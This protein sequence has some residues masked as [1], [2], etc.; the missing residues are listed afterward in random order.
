ME[1]GVDFAKYTL[2]D[3]DVTRLEFY[4]C[5]HPFYLRSEIDRS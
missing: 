3:V 2:G 5:H 4:E 1:P